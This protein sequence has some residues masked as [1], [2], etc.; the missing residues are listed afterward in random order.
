MADNNEQTGTGGALDHAIS[1]GNTGADQPLGHNDGA[2]LM[3]G[4]SDDA[5]GSLRSGSLYGQ[6]DED[7]DEDDLDEDDEDLEEEDLDDEE[8]DQY[9]D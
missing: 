7:D 2:G 8:E 9:E 3:P 1:G 4:E 5:S 6:R